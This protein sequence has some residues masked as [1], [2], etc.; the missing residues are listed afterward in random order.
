M[1]MQS[2]KGFQLPFECRNMEFLK[3][4]TP[5]VFE[6]QSQVNLQESKVTSSNATNENE[7]RMHV[8]KSAVSAKK[9]FIVKF[10]SNEEVN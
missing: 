10:R 2:L 5:L 3:A 8:T 4:C 7:R 9:Y 6:K 1:C